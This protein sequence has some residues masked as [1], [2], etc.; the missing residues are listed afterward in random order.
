LEGDLHAQIASVVTVAQNMT[1]VAM[2]LHI[3]VLAANPLLE[4]AG[5]LHIPHP[6]LLW[7]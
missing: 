3:V 1:S 4:Y 6:A 2:I 5:H 7:I